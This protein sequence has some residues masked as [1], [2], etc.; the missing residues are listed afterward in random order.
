MTTDDL[1]AKIRKLLDRTVDRGCTEA[2]AEAAMDAAARLMREHG[3]AEEDIHYT[4]AWTHR[5]APKGATPRDWFI[6]AIARGLGCAVYRESGS[7]EGVFKFYGLD[8]YPHVAAYMADR[9]LSAIDTELRQFRKT[10]YYKR[11][12]TK[13][14]KT[15]A[16]KAF[17]EGMCLRLSEKVTEKFDPESQIE[18]CAKAE[19]LMAKQVPSLTPGQSAKRSSDYATQA[20]GRMAAGQYEL[21]D[22]VS[23]RE[24]QPKLLGSH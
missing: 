8:P 21:H 2:E 5:S 17:I 22:G 12:R 24:T 7:V 3:L 6:S 15:A 4:L 20:Y 23:G 9:C 19:A 10:T 1:K 16:G 11:K 13:K 18:A 14:A